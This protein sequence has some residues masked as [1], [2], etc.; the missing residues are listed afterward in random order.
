MRKINSNQHMMTLNQKHHSVPSQG[1]PWQK[2]ALFAPAGKQM[3]TALQKET[4]VRTKNGKCV[5][6]ITALSRSWPAGVQQVM[7]DLC[8]CTQAYVAGV[9][10]WAPLLLHFIHGYYYN[11]YTIIYLCTGL[12]L[13]M[14]TLY[15][16]SCSA[17]LNAP[18]SVWWVEI[19]NRKRMMD[20][21][22]DRIYFGSISQCS[23]W[24]FSRQTTVLLSSITVF[25]YLIR[26]PD[27]GPIGQSGTA[28]SSS[29]VGCIFY[30]NLY[31]LQHR[32]QRSTQC[33][34]VW[35]VADTGACWWSH[36]RGGVTCNRANAGEVG[37]VIFN[38]QVLWNKCW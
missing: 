3:A 27:A 32:C 35:H 19:L 8:R 25:K 17:Y 6:L 26:P 34:K 28:L 20:L 13:H 38:I 31:N 37:A 21:S 9:D 23:I 29:M 33:P 11:R 4:A 5:I 1:Q 14:V 15:S 36:E 16:N 18:T 12:P 22:E 2:A 30:W 7:V 10:V 24:L